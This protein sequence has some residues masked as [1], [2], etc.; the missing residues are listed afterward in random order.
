MKIHEQTAEALTR[1]V[2]ESWDGATDESQTVPDG[3]AVRKPAEHETAADLRRRVL[4]LEAEVRSVRAVLEVRNEAFRSLMARLVAVEHGAHAGGSGC[5][6]RAQLIAERDAAI[7][8]AAV[9]QNMKVFRYSTWPRAMYAA[10]L[11]LRA[12]R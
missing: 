5:E 2:E 6:D 12:G 3:S 8:L 1:P 10:L 11:R 9:L 4:G 7:E